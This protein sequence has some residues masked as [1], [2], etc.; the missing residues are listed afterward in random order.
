MNK[1]PLAEELFN[2]IGYAE[3]ESWTLK[4]SIRYLDRTKKK[5]I[6]FYKKRKTFRV[7][8]IDGVTD[9]TMEELKAILCKCIELN[10]LGKDMSI[11]KGIVI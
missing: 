3:D 11:W 10:M 5:G 7:Y 2:N 1:M 6:V 4:D 8:S 9:V